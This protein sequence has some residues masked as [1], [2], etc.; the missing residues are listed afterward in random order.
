MTFEN[1]IENMLKEIVGQW[2][3]FKTN[4]ESPLHDCRDMITVQM[5][6]IL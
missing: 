3:N 4:T 1:Q 5:G 6:F 2:K